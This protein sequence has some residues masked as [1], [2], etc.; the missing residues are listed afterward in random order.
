M[1][2]TH[3]QF[4]AANRAAIDSLLAQ[5]QASLSN[6]ER[7][8]ALNL[9]TSRAFFA[10]SIAAVGTLMTMK[11]PREVMALQ[12]V[13]AKSTLE[14]GAA[15]SRSVQAIVADSASGL[16]QAI[17]SQ[18]ADLKKNFSIAIDRSLSSAPA[19]SEPMVAAVRSVLAQ[20]DS[21]YATLTESSRQA[22]A[23]V[24]STLASA[25]VAAVKMMSKAA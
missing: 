1:I 2:Q 19:G 17:E 15:Y 18:A 14:K 24:E 16:T 3:E 11:N 10:D 5:F 8:A 9:E 20:A 7:L 22:R 6:V 23:L 21:A 13:L 4:T 12:G 25:N